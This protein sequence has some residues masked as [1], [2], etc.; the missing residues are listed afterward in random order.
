MRSEGSGTA[1]PPTVVLPWQENIPGLK[2]RWETWVKGLNRDSLFLWR[3][4]ALWVRNAV[5]LRNPTARSS[6]PLTQWTSW[7]WEPWPALCYL[8]TLNTHI[9]SMILSPRGVWCLSGP[10]HLA[11]NIFSPSQAHWSKSKNRKQSIFSMARSLR[12]ISLNI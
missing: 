9:S 4:L 3:I 8:H 7:P 12:G 5:K 11:C 10:N 2:E 6:E 1:F